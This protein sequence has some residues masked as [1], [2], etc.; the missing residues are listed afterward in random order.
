MK[1]FLP[2]I[3]LIFSS[4]ILY[5]Q[6]DN[7]DNIYKIREQVISKETANNS[8]SNNEDS[9]DELARF[10][11]WF[12]MAEVRS[13]PSGNLV[14]G[15]ALLQ[16]YKEEHHANK[17]AYKLTGNPG[18]W[19][20]LGPKTVPNNHNGIGRINCITI[21]PSDTNSIYVGAACGGVWISH[22]SGTTWT[23]N[24][25]NF[26]SLSVTDIAVN[27]RHTD[28]IYAATGD[29]Y[30]FERDSIYNFFWG[31]LYSAGVVMSSDG[32]NT[33]TTTGLSYQ[34]TNRNIIQ[35]LIIHP[36]HPNILMAGSREGIF[37]TTDAG[38]TWQNVYPNH[39]YNMAFRPGRPDTVYAVT[40]TALIVSYNAG[41]TWQILN[42]GISM[43]YNQFG[44]YQDRVSIAVSAASPNSIWILDNSNNL[45]YSHDGGHTFYSSLGFPSAYFY[46][47]Y[48]RVLA[49]SPSDSNTIL[50]F[51]M[52]M[53][54]ST[55]GG[56]TWHQLDM[57]GNVHADNHTAT[58][59]P[60][61]SNTFYSGND[62]GIFVTRDNGSTW[63]NITDGL[64]ISQ[65]YRSSSSRQNP[66]II[67]C[68]L[69]DNGT[70]RYN[71]SNWT[72]VIYADGMDCAIYPKNDHYQIGSY[73]DGS[74]LS[75][76]DQGNTFISLSITGYGP[77]TSP[78]VFNP[79]SP[80]TIY[81]GLEG[82]YATYDQ[83]STF[84]NLT[85][86]NTFSIPGIFTPGAT[87]IAISSSNT[88]V[89]Y[90]ANEANII[91]TTD[92]GITWNDVTGNL[93]SDSVAITHIAV[94]FKNPMR[95]FVTTSGYIAGQKV[96]VS[97]TGG[98]N[99][100]NISK[101]LPN[102][103][104]NCIAVD[105]STKGALFVGTDMGIY[106]SDSSLNGWIKYSSG[107]PNVIVDD[108]D[109]NYTNYK[110]RAA[111]YG[112]GLWECDLPR[113]LLSVEQINPSP[114][115]VSIYPNPTNKNWSIIFSNDRPSNYII[116]VTNLTGQI[117]FK[118]QNPEYIN[119]SLFPPGLYFV[120]IYFADT[121]SYL[122]AIK[123]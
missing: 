10:N 113:G 26:P 109:V 101:N 64:V 43:A 66:N 85:P 98:T 48:D 86:T 40:N 90:A 34:Q 29:Q 78:I 73:Q 49:V 122:K 5:A 19:Q 24:S 14:H 115:D 93:P 96:F 84:V 74:F 1:T 42:A 32:G 54:Q 37:R 45:K 31:G 110:I 8:K 91:L 79:N 36:N 59:N 75:S 47:Y 120:D 60:L 39:V 52:S 56:N 61:H 4:F 70:L 123:N 2:L 82:I 30:G 7:R 15:D 21:L 13:Y 16:A 41:A 83:G 88:K 107:L 77:W 63:N 67:L 99:W 27:P 94:D 81:F 92:G 111:T 46:G 100:T 38:A 102:I 112:R 65:I 116:R 117:V 22:N 95:V 20:S 28:T 89:L 33:W 87:S 50:A 71:G 53:S 12:Y 55:D 62:G 105:S 118:E 119:A 6:S 3:T 44:Y 17:Q 35:K 58:F 103:P 25:D 108:I 23:S 121:H 9:D 114:S 18:P 11:R 72:H 104:A 57:T 106:Y 97:N 80:D 69:Q 68:G 51:G 76:T